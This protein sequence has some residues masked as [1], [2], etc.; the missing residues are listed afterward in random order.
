[1]SRELQVYN[2]FSGITGGVWRDGDVI[3]KR[4]R[5][6][7]EAL[8][9]WTPSD[10]PTDA[11]YW[12]READVY[13]SGLPA[14]LGLGAPRLLGSMKTDDGVELELSALA[15]RTA[16]AVTVDDLQ[17]LARTLGR[18]QG[19]ADLPREPWLSR[20]F[21]RF[22]AMSGRT[23]HSAMSDDGIWDRRYATPFV[24]DQI[25]ADILAMHANR[26]RL[27]SIAES[28][29]RTICHLDLFPNNVFATD[30][31][32]SLIDWSFTGDGALGEDI[33]N[34]I[35]DS[36]FDL[37]LPASALPELEITLPEHYIAGLREAGWSGDDRLVHLGI[38]ASAIKYDWFAP[39]LLHNADNDEQR[40]YGGAVVDIMEL[41][42][43]RWEGLAMLGRWARQAIA[44]AEAL[45]R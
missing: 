15:G 31:S 5:T 45:R 35:P 29:P 23:D 16:G 25:R 42:A 19:R 38:H 1:M 14:R 13:E 33:G 37:A 24:T 28:L 8:P 21:L 43:A 2:T 30:D 11:L 44:E 9:W 26:F 32:V 6:S 40:G 39:R 18:S 41:S 36:I 20:G 17:R 3:I 27:L 7:A 10:N 34:L 22:W 12:R 4:L